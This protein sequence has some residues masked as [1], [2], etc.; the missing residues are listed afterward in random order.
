MLQQLLPDEL[1]V[2]WNSNGYRGCDAMSTP[3][4]SKPARAYPT[5]QPPAPQNR[6][7]S[8]GF[9]LLGLFLLPGVLCA[10]L[11]VDA[12]REG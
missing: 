4:T 8:L 6:S 3:T 12:S 7:S 2:E 11:A 10:A 1:G 9:T 5:L